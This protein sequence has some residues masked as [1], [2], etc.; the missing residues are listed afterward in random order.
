[1]NSKSFSL[2][3]AARASPWNERAVDDIR[4]V[5]RPDQDLNGFLSEK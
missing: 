2:I 3:D 1:M 4:P 5:D